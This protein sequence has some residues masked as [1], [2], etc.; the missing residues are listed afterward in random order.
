MPNNLPQK[1]NDPTSFLGVDFDTSMADVLKDNQFQGEAITRILSSC[2]TALNKLQFYCQMLANESSILSARTFEAVT[3]L[4][5]NK[6]YKY[7][8]PNSAAGTVR[9]YLGAAVTIDTE[10]PL[11]TVLK[12]DRALSYS[13]MSPLL[14]PAGQLYADIPVVQGEFHTETF[15][16]QVDDQRIVKLGKVKLSRSHVSVSVNGIPYTEKESI[17]DASSGEYIFEV[18]QNAE[19]IYLIF[20]NGTIGTRLVEGDAIEVKYLVTDGLSGNT[21]RDTITMISDDHPLSLSVVNKTD[22]TGGTD[23]ED[24]ETIRENAQAAF[25][26]QWQVT[27]AESAIKIAKLHPYVKYA[28]VKY[29]DK[30][31]IYPYKMFKI[32]VGGTGGALSEEVLVDIKNFMQERTVADTVVEVENLKLKSTAFQIDL[33][34]QTRKVADNNLYTYSSS[35]ILDEIKTRLTTLICPDNYPPEA[36]IYL[37]DVIVEIKKV[38][39]VLGVTILDPAE[40]IELEYDEIPVFSE[41][42][43]NE[44]EDAL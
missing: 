28:N 18:N 40:D 8:L 10:M 34:I 25:W 11:N 4:A 14:I 17:F 15:V 5:L 24:I 35:E 7:A 36:V 27:T 6:G 33:T 21:A 23:Q 20:G 9:F 13:T 29:Q 38:D 39:G 32:L 26:T 44:L 41:I 31:E 2:S 1:I 30:T 19:E 16:A 37:A 43:I 42:Y 22:I 12:S 3:T